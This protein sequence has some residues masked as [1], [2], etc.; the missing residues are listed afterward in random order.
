MAF[1]S[2]AGSSTVKTSDSVVL[3]QQKAPPARAA[4]VFLAAFKRKLT[5]KSF[6]RLLMTK[7]YFQ[8]ITILYEMSS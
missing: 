3:A 2:D 7:R 6:G 5:S 4:P 1:G 8:L